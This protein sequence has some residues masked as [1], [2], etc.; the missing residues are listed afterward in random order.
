[1]VRITIAFGLGIWAARSLNINYIFL[2]LLVI[3]LFSAEAAFWHKNLNFGKSFRLTIVL[4]AAWFLAG[5]L[6]MDCAEQKPVGSIANYDE[7]T[8]R[9]Q[10]K[11]C[12]TPTVSAG[13]PGEWK[14]RYSVDLNWIYPGENGRVAF[15][16]KGGA[17]LTVSQQM[18]VAKVSVA[19]VIEQPINEWDEFT[20]R[21]E[22]PE[23]V[24]VRPRVSGY[25]DKVAFDEG[26]LVKKVD[27]LF[28]IDP[29]PFQAEV[30]RLQAQL[31]QARASQTL[32]ANEAR[33]GER[34]KLLT[35]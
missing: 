31:Q 12:E 22:A 28:Q 5:L 25:I 18:P 21:L 4:V 19:E 27:L 7:Q 16:V 14:I 3:L 11:I 20:G 13:M 9:I 26:S 34:R 30:K 15:P 6:R 32:A 8:V 17:F 29:R 24:E 35:A 33:R 2:V 10:G 1:M 23:S